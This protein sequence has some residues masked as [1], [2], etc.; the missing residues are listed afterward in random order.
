MDGRRF[1]FRI[2]RLFDYRDSAGH[3]RFAGLFQEFLFAA[4]L[5]YPAAVLRNIA[6]HVCASAAVAPFGSAHSV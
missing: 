2:V 3:E 1:V 4:H 6:V 5:A